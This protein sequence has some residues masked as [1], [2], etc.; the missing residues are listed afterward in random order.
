LRGLVR[1]ASLIE[2]LRLCGLDLEHLK[3]ALSE[4]FE[5]LLELSEGSKKLN[6]P[7]ATFERIIERCVY[8]GITTG[9][10]VVES[11]RC[12]VRKIEPRRFLQ[13]ECIARMR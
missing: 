9:R 8:R 2:I 3:Q 6:V 10:K 7:D 4:Y 13:F 5:R 11:L 1:A 12:R